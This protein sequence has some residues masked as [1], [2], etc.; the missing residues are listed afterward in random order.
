[1]TIH[2]A[3][4]P[5]DNIDCMYQ[6]NEEEEMPAFKIAS[7]HWF[8]NWKNTYKNHGGRLITVSKNNID[9]T[10]INRTKITKK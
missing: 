2:K 1:M 10:S 4:H 8:N 7:M 9:Y 3:L 5:R 6:E